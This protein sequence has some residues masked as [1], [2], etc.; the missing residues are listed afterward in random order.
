MT[1]LVQCPGGKQ[2]A[3]IIPNSVTS[4]GSRAFYNCK[5]L[6][7]VTIPNSV[8]SIGSSAFRSCTGLKSVTIGSGVANI[9]YGAFYKCIDLTSVTNYATTPQTID[10]SVFESVGISS[11]TLHV[12]AESVE[13]YKAADV[14]KEFWEITTIGAEGIEDA[15]SD[16]VQ[17]TKILRNGQIFIQRGEKIYT[18]TGQE[19]QSY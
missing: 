18:I 12:P 19:I 13:A 15:Q 9:G 6:T 1:T 8:T 16:Q 7:S 17:N 5:G 3:Y 4:I 10:Y 14:W 11:C 2:G